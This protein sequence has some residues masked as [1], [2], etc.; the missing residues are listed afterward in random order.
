MLKKLFSI[1]CCFLLAV[2]QC[3]VS[4]AET[5]K[6]EETLSL[7]AQAAVLLDGKSGRVLYGYQ[8]GKCLPMASTTKIMTCI[9]VLELGGMEDFAEVSAKAQSMPKVHLSVKEGEYYKISDLLYSLMLESHNDSA[10]VLAEYIG[11]SV[12]GF[13]GLMNQKAAEIGCEQT[14]FVT[15]NGLDAENHK[16]TAEELARI[17]RYCIHV[18][19]KKEEFLKITRTGTHTFSNYEMEGDVPKAGNRSF[20]V[21]NKNAFLSMMEGALSG[22]TGFTSAAGYCYVGALERDGKL[23]IVAL[24]GCGW[25]G[26]KG[27][28]WEDT[29]K[30]MEYGLSSFTYREWYEPPKLPV[31]MVSGAK[32]EEEKETSADRLMRELVSPAGKAE[33][34]LELKEQPEGMLLK[35]SDRIVMQMTIAEAMEAPVEKGTQAG[36]VSYYLNGKLFAGFP[37]VVGKTMEK[38]DFRWIWKKLLQ[39]Y[40]L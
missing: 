2:C 10:V 23:L 15:P 6:K 28:K 19:E 8:E 17:M 18:S 1:L 40:F 22:K 39:V 32:T 35:E 36:K 20:T 11:G 24:L 37:V 14:N 9:L 5:E 25:P 27:W 31:L 13:A 30:L 7:H 12:E 16:T 38:T 29:R 21:N 33:L 3:S 4:F 34:V 26:H